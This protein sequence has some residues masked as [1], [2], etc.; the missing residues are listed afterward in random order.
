MFIARVNLLLDD[1][2]TVNFL[3]CHSQGCTKRDFRRLAS[4]VSN[5]LNNLSGQIR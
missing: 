2:G 3:N 1:V 4:L 5:Y